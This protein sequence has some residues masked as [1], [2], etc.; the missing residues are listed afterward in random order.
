MQEFATMTCVHFVSRTEEKDYVNILSGDGCWS[1]VGRTGG[2][3]TVSLSKAGCANYGVAQHELTHSLGFYHEHTRR[4]RDDYIDIMWQYISPE[5]NGYFKI[6]EGNT[7][8]LPYD[9]NSVMHYG[10]SSYSNTSGRPSIVPI[11]DPDV[12]IGQRYGLSSLDVKKINTLYDCNLC[13][14]KF[15]DSEGTFSANVASLDE[16]GGSCLWLIQVL[17]SKTPN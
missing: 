13:R 5:D 1:D 14:A 8:N 10:K 17:A 3:Q 6:D 12:R 9:Y 4:D 11:P 15:L 7:M 16:D 2:K